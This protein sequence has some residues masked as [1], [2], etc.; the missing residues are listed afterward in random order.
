MRNESGQ[1]VY[2]RLMRGNAQARSIM[3]G[4]SP[5]QSAMREAVDRFFADL[6]QNAAVQHVQV[7]ILH[8]GGTEIYNAD[9]KSAPQPKEKDM[10]KA[11]VVNAPAIEPPRDS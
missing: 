6:M 11:E 1:D 8:G 7:T 5:L 2:N 9:R 3:A 10:G 4:K